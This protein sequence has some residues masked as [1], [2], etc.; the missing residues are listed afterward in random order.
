M[1]VAADQHRSERSSSCVTTNK[2]FI[3][4]SSISHY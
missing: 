3:A 2:L 1:T 4:S